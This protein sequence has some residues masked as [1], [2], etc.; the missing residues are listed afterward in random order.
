MPTTI[1]VFDP[2][3]CCSTG[4]CGPSV[5]PDLARFAGDLSWIDGQGVGVRRYNL[6]QEPGAFATRDIVRSA[7]ESGGEKA[8]PVILVD[9]R[10]KWIGHYP[11]REELA[12]AADLTVQE[13]GCCG[14][15]VTV[16][17]GDEQPTAG[18]C[19]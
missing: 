9:G 5:E 17:L 11:T 2:A 1:E 8:L 18:G 13:D 19:C 10:L 16:Q 15:P 14:G 7:L 6:G 12:A 4:V 3:M